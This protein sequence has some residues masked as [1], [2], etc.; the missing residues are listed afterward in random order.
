MI[1][2]MLEVTESTLDEGTSKTQSN[3]AQVIISYKAVTHIYDFV[4]T[5][6]YIP[7]NRLSAEK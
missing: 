3:G 6:P 7:F 1:W 4:Y 5:I 2:R